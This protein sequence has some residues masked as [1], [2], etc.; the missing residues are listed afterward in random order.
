[1]QALGLKPAVSAFAVN[2]DTQFSPPGQQ[3]TIAL[4]S[5]SGLPIRYTIDGSPPSAASRLY[6]A[7][8]ALAFP[9]HLRA[10]TLYRDRPLP[11]GLDGMIDAR[12]V[13]RRSDEVLQ[14][15]TDGAR[16][17]LEDDFPAAGPRAVFVTDIMSPCWIFRQ[18]PVG[19]AKQIAI[20]VGQVP[21]NFQVGKDIENIHF[22]PPATPAGEFEVRAP[23]CNGER[24][25]V[26]PLAPAQTNPG[27]TR[28]VAPIAPRQRNEDLCFTYT[29]KAVNPMWAIDSVELIAQ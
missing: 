12:S 13:R 23:G 19:G 5:Q 22:R 25:A 10:A 16:L 26:L 20:D 21:F 17:A 2:A 8:L 1:M 4:S 28:L 18:A 14:T 7:P 11:G 9:A 24:I 15:C 6:S 3:A 27:I 29:A